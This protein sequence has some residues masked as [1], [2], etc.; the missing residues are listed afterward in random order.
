MSGE[1]GDRSIEEEPD[2]T[3]AHA[4]PNM[5]P[6]DI[7][8]VEQA[9]QQLNGFSAASREEALALVRHSKMLNGNLSL[10]NYLRRL[11]QDARMSQDGLCAAIDLPE[12]AVQ[13]IEG[14]EPAP[15]HLEPEDLARWA[16]RIG[17]LQRLTAALLRKQ[18][19]Y[20]RLS[21]RRTVNR[22]GDDL[23]SY[24]DN[25]SSAFASYR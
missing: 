1:P 3:V 19:E 11:R 10:G 21:R 8:K 24:I 17:A 15:M 12:S 4:L 20:V 14:G 6:Q 5:K 2:D 18:N 16:A 23:E 9:D 7:H 25:F 22:P 13:S